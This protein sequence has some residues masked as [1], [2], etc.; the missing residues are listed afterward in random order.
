MEQATSAPTLMD[1]LVESMLSIGARFS[2]DN[3]PGGV[4]HQLTTMRYVFTVTLHVCLLEVGSEAM[5]VLQHQH[6]HAE[7]NQGAPRR[8]HDR[9]PTEKDSLLHM[10]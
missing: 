2:P 4:V 5:Q 7:G 8:S 6:P 3:G 10:A 9:L 1:E